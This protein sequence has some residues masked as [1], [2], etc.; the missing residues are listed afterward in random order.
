M[1]ALLLGDFLCL[2]CTNILSVAKGATV[3][4]QMEHKVAICDAYRPYTVHV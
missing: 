1:L 2:D 3:Y 4:A